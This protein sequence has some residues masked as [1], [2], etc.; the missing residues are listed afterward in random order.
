MSKVLDDL[1]YTKEH[2][3]VKVKDDGNVIVGITDYAQSALG[4]VVFVEPP[5]EGAQVEAG[6]TVS[7]IESVKA[8]SD[9]YSPIAGTIVEANGGLEG[10]PAIVNKEPYDNGWL[11]VIQPENAGDIDGLMS[12]KDY[13][14]FVATL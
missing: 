12:A 11:F 8:V 1:K 5:E 4:D 13:S 7:T 10:D 6:A 3:W 2:E 14:D 9:I